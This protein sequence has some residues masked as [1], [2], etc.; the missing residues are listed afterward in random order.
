M[1]RVRVI[2]QSW[3]TFSAA[4]LVLL[5]VSGCGSRT[6]GGAIE[7]PPEC[8]RDADCEG[9]ADRC[10]PVQCNRG[11]CEELAPVDCED[12]NPC[13][14]DVCDPLTGACSYP[15][16]TVDLDHDGHLAPLPGKLAGE[17]GACGDDCDDRNP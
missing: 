1:G 3:Q 9:A 11:V 16:A 2:D 7:G 5:A 15:D 14:R 12:K 10:L 4:P 6:P 13:T 8:T 17:D